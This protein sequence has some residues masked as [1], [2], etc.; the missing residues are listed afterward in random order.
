MEAIAQQIAASSGPSGPN[1]EY[2][3]QLAQAMWKV[4]FHLSAA[5]CIL[6]VVW[7]MHCKVVPYLLC[8]H[9]STVALVGAVR[10]VL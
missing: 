8:G 7:H 6:A 2:L 9:F 10:P 4:T 3:E 1:H 5:E